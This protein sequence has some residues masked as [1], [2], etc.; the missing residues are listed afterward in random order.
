MVYLHVVLLIEIIILAARLGGIGVGLAGGLGMAIAVFLF[1]IKPGEMPIDVILI[2]LSVI[3]A[4]SA[5]QNAGGLR[6]MVQVAEKLLRN[7]PRYINFLAPLTTFVLTV[8]SG[9]AYTTLSVLKVIQEVAK[10]IGVRP[11]QPLTAAV[12]SCQIAITASPIS[13]ATAAMYVVVEKMGVPYGD[14]LLV[15]VPTGFVAICVA[16]FVASRQG[17]ELLNDPIFID[18]KEKGLIE[19]GIQDS[20]ELPNSH[21]AKRAVYLFLAS[22]VFIVTMLIFKP[23]IGHK[24]GSRDIIIITMF[25]TTLLIVVTCNVSL[26]SIK[27]ASLFSDGTE[28]LVVILGIAWLSG[29]IIGAYIPEIKEQ[30]GEILRQYPALLALVFFITSAA[31]FSH[32][33]A[34]ALLIPIAASLGIEASTIVGAFV[35]MNA[36]YITNIYPT[37]AYAIAADDTGSYMSKRWNGS[38]LVN[39]PFILPGLCGVGAALPVGFFLA[40]T[41]IGG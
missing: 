1:G 5:M 11:S 39:H 36:M 20:K 13:A 14:V 18:R 29:S 30:A 15:I 24:I 10:S 34:A 25:V 23:I 35:A 27:K 28:S 2:I 26:R 4:L 31:L 7:H 40:N 22:V 8:L 16:A 21:L 3:L 38:Y 12:V 19:A 33:A 41:F 37:A 6:F 32:G 17:G 9:T